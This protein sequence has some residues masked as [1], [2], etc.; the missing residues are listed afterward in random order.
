MAAAC[1]TD[2]L[3]ACTLALAVE[4][5][6][7]KRF[8]IPRR[9]PWEVSV[10]VNTTA[11]VLPRASPGLLWDP[12]LSVWPCLVTNECYTSDAVCVLWSGG[13]HGTKRVYSARVP[14][15]ECA[16]M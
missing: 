14:G 9:A 10:S 12:Q 4:A 1:G 8:L 15:A 7:L 6:A 11:V 16:L 2:T 5:R 13:G 3:A